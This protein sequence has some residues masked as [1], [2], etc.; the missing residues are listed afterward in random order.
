MRC[1]WD[2]LHPAPPEEFPVPLV[3]SDD[4]L[5]ASVLMPGPV[6]DLARDMERAGWRAQ[7]TYA[8][9]Y[10]P[11]ATHG[12]PSAK[13]KQS[14]AVRAVRGA[15][16]AV[17]VRED[18]AWQSLWDWSA[19]HFFRRSPGLEVFVRATVGTPVCFPSR[20]EWDAMLVKYPLRPT[21][22]QWDEMAK[23][24]AS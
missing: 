24:R 9:G 16:R 19:E 11:H 2:A 12:R 8:H 21:R 13:P 15:Q 22:K 1:E 10:V 3:T 17:A 14:W 7:I 6:A 20:T 4:P 23:A 5:P 18:D